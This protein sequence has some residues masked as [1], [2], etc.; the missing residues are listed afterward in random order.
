[1][2][3]PCQFD[4]LPTSG[5]CRAA[6]GYRID[7]GR[8]GNT[9]LDGVK[10]VRIWAWPGP[11]HE[12]R[13][14]GLL[15]VDEQASSAQHDAVHALFHGEETEP[16]ATI[17]NVFAPVIDTFHEPL[18]APIDF[19]AN[20]EERTGHFSVPGVIHARGGPIKNPVSGDP[21]RARVTLPHG[22][23]YHEAEYGR[24]TVGSGKSSIALDHVD[25]HAHFAYLDW[26]RNGPV[27]G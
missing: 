14:E 12:G 25:A 6:A 16:G 8:F 22:F 19:D 9:T 11:I 13:G 27:H 2:G 1:V 23:E 18:R 21:H 3:C 26:T 20:V 15:I 17:F 24:S 7:E 5:D 10:F 4:S